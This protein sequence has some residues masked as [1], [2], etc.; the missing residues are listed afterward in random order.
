MTKE[1][2]FSNA[3][4]VLE[5]EIVEGSVLVRDG[6]I[7]DISGGSS[8]VGEDFEGDY[9]I[10]G[11]VELHTDHL[12]GHYSPRPGLRWNKTAAI[13]A[14]DAQIVTSGITTVFDCLRMGADEDGGFEHGEMRDMADAIQKAEKEGRLRAEHLIHLRCEVSADNVLQHFADFENDPYVRLVSLMDH[15]PGQRQFQTMDQY[16]F[17]YQKKRGLTDAEFAKFVDRRVSESERNS[18]P[19]RVAIAK[20]CAE[21]GITVASHDDATLAHVDE[22]I[23]NGVR[24]AEFPTSFDAA[25][26]SH[27]NGMSVLMGAPNIV[28]GKSHSGN[29]AARD[30][31]ERGVL[32]VLSSDYV[33]LSL[34]YAPFLIADEVESISLPKAIAM[35]TST[36]ARTVSLNDRGRIA[37]GLRADLVRVFRDEGVPVSRSVWREGRRV[38]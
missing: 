37:T 34:L 18:T 35:V 15:A 3:R 5:D 25:E 10:P 17:Y 11:L 31:A 2:V 6:K 1:T 12:E 30:L 28:R 36:P 9:L 27:E 13:Q 20:V 22:A 26:A 32:D 21:R 24:L 23:E 4:I 38:A 7:E 16:I 29:I 8:R 33:P 19:H 14:H